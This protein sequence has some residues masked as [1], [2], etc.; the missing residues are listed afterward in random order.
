[1]VQTETPNVIKPGV[2][3]EEWKRPFI[4]D[5]DYVRY[6]SRDLSY[7][8]TYEGSIKEYIIRSIEWFTGKITLMTLIR[9]YERTARPP[10]QTF[11]GKA[12]DLLEIEIQTPIEQLNRFPLEGPLVVVANHPHGLVDGL[13]LAELLEKTRKD[14]KI[15]TRELLSKVPEIQ[16]NL[17]PVAFPHEDDTV[18]KN[19]AMRKIAIDHL[20]S[21][22]SII[23][24]PSGQV[25][26][27]RSWGTSAIE[28]D[29][30]LFTCKLVRMGRA[31]I[32]PVYFP[33]ENSRWYHWANLVSPTLR[34][35]LLL[36]EIVHSMRKPQKPVIGEVIEHEEFNMRSNDP[37][38]F[39]RWLRNK[40]LSLSQG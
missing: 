1:M 21:G 35:S 26:S 19:I 30:N 39:M 15:L 25:A 33:G 5:P 17:L 18:R 24:F 36:H 4:E 7:G 11:Y 10:N 34:Q 40:T 23:L 29:W 14:F 8:S 37:E 16:Q 32:V 31:Q 2:I 22:G 9:K 3:N 12:L 27:A 13:I 38:A 28:A 6:K 20:R